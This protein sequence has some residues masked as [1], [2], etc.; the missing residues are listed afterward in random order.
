MYFLF[1]ARFYLLPVFFLVVQHSF[2]LDVAFLSLIIFSSFLIMLL[3][4]QVVK[5]EAEERERKKRKDK[6]RERKHV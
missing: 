3:S 1:S 4:R 6:Q 5:S 2:F